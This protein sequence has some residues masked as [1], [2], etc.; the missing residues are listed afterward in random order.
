MLCL[1][2]SII[3]IAPI[4]MAGVARWARDIRNKKHNK[5]CAVSFIHRLRVNNF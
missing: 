2:V 5:Q 1:L 3:P 4:Q